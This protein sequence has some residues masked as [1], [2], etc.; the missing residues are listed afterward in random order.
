[1]EDIDMKN[2]PST[3]KVAFWRTTRGGQKD[4]IFSQSG[5]QSSVSASQYQGQDKET[6]TNVPKSQIIGEIMLRRERYPPAYARP[7]GTYLSHIN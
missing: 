4:D 6:A 2:L 5:L 3:Y 7:T 1:M